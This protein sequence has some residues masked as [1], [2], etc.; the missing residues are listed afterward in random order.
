MTDFNDLPTLY[1]ISSSE[2]NM[3]SSTVHQL[4]DEWENLLK[5]K[6]EIIKVLLNDIS[7]QQKYIKNLKE[8]N[9][10]LIREKS[11]CLLQ[12]VGNV[13]HNLEVPLLKS[14][15]IQTSNKFSVL[16]PEDEES[17]SHVVNYAKDVKLVN[18]KKPNRNKNKGEECVRD[19][20]VLAVKE[21]DLGRSGNN[22]NK[23]FKKNC[24]KKVG[25][26]RKISIYAD[27][28]GREISNILRNVVDLADNYKVSCTLKP[29]AKSNSVTAECLEESVN[30]TGKDF[31]VLI[32]GSNDVACD[33]T[34]NAVLNINT[35]LRNLNHTNVIIVDL[36]H[37]YDLRAESCV[38]KEVEIANKQIHEICDRFKNVET[39][40]IGSMG[41]RFHTAHGQHLNRIGKKVLVDKIT[42]TVLKCSVDITNVPVELPSIST[43]QK[44]K[45]VDDTLNSHPSLSNS[46]VPTVDLILF[47]D[48]EVE[49]TA[50]SDTS[51]D[52]CFHGFSP[53]LKN[54]ISR[55]DNLISVENT[56]V[57]V[58][59]CSDTS[60]DSCF[61]GFSPIPKG[62]ISQNTNLI[63]VENTHT[64]FLV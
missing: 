4:N 23:V 22:K 2:R 51:S 35:M 19:N 44:T 15:E 21:I 54:K 37:R 58:T 43:S 24:N 40:S 27:S 33:E 47:D 42:N 10:A 12:E 11:D 32:T 6:E 1:S 13:F 29:G 38:N 49:V 9:A 36:P 61:N 48:H 57:E 3:A 34:K 62:K 20:A 63:T 46:E 5:T 28:H 56:Q 50:C 55:N 39:I 16:L 59:A 25:Q 26:E 17:Y 18:R 52:S 14:C 8:E 45:D 7:E 31:V 53:I 30:L 64:N 41:R 60:S